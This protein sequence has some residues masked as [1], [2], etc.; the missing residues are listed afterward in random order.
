MVA[1][2]GF[3]TVDREGSASGFLWRR[4]GG[5]RAAAH[6]PNTVD[7]IAALR[8]VI[9]HHRPPQTTTP[10]TD[11][12]RVAIRSGQAEGRVAQGGAGRAPARCVQGPAEPAIPA[13]AL[14]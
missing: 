9:T 10:R 14:W 13:T 11:P 1:G 3:N 2:T 6:H 8:Q 7:V 12:G 5:L 4:E